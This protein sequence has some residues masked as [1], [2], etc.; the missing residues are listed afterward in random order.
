MLSIGALLDR[1]QVD[2]H[3]EPWFERADQPRSHRFDSEAEPPAYRS[4]SSTPLP[5]IHLA[6]AEKEKPISPIASRVGTY[7]DDPDEVPPHATKPTPDE[8]VSGL[9]SAWPEL[10]EEGAQTLAAQFMAETGGGK[11][12]FNWNLG[13]VKA[14][15]NEPHMYLRNVWEVDTIDGA[16]AAAEASALA[17]V[18]T[19]EEIKKHGWAC[20]AGKAIVVFQPPHAACRF[21]A[22]ASLADGARKWIAFQKGVAGR[23]LTYLGALNRGDV[24]AV[25][26][27]LKQARCY[28]A[29]EADYARLLAAKKAELDASTAPDGDARAVGFHAKRE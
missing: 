14:G 22:Y 8:V 25:A 26:H 15:P 28:T 27:A 18:A 6:E 4:A 3:E 16:R 5:F 21:R 19:P 20:P 24:A 1:R 23:N 2:C 12:C 13:N 17:H 29:A 10:T 9:R 7:T 11:Y